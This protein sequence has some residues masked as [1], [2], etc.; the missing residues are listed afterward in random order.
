MTDN[1]KIPGVYVTESNGLSLSIQTGQTA[2]PVFAFD[3][4]KT[5]E[6]NPAIIRQ[7]DV[8]SFSSWLEVSAALLSESPPNDDGGLYQSL[9]LFFLNGGGH[10]YVAP[11]SK[12][13]ALVPTLDDVTLLV[14]AGVSLETFNSKVSTLC[15]AGKTLFAVFDG[16]KR[17][18][19]S[20]SDVIAEAAH[21]PTTPYAAVYFPWLK[22]TGVTTLVPPSG[23]VAGIYARVDR[24]RGVWKAPANVELI[25]A[26][27]CFKV[28]D[29][30]DGACNAPVSGGKSINVIRAF[31]GTGPLIWGARTLDSDKKTWR[32]VPV[33]R[34]FN[35]A[36]RDIRTAMSSALF[37]PNSAP[38]WERVR[39][40][41]ENYLHGLWQQG[42][43]LGDSPAQAYFVQIGRGTTMTQEDINNGRMIV[44][45]GLA[46]VR[47]AEFIVLQLTQDVAAA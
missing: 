17:E 7:D 10:C 38:T 6:W 25:G 36:E 4:K 8:A 18:L 1:Y 20:A 41:V 11:V 34:L 33:R 28:S 9:K 2:V 42:A 29:A 24:Q 46:A 14:Q 40:A 15:V 5:T 37:E 43:L 19:T 31:Q 23:A 44:K 21:Y 3:F 39:G 30:I 32:Y 45:V 12:L 16:P 35:A 26:T 22:V 47:P 13:D 27:P